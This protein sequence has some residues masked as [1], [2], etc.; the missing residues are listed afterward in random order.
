MGKPSVVMVSANFH[1]YIGG[2]EKQA[3]EL[4]RALRETGVEVTVL[5]RR[6]LRL[7]ASETLDGVLIRRLPAWGVGLV[8]SLVFMTSCF[9]WLLTHPGR[10]AAV[11]VH[12]AGSPALAACL[13]GRLLGKRVIVKLGGGKGIGELAASES[14]F[15]GRLKL[16][17]LAALG[18]QFVAV[19]RELVA[20]LA[21]HGLGGA[22]VVIQ[23]NGVD[24]RAYHPPSAEEKARL[25]IDLRMPPGL[26]FLYVG[27]LA[28]EKRLDLFV[29][30]L[31]RAL[32]EAP[33]EAYA[34]LVGK[35]DL[36][37]MLRE[38]A[39]ASGLKGRVRFMPPTPE[40]MQLYRA[41]DVF[42]LPSI[43]EGLSNALL[44]A[45]ASGLAV[46][47]SRVG[48]SAEAIVD[49]G[50]GFL[51][52]PQ[53]VATFR[54]RIVQLLKNPGLAEKLGLRGRDDVL[55]RFDLGA[56]A[57]RYRELYGFPG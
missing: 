8:D 30:E 54:A 22:R 48:G 44:E 31:G 29:E 11:H 39:M 53:D 6:I 15:A 28:P 36:E 21:D 17:A 32:K 12:L 24:T 52:E 33:A 13:A 10:Y 25:R 38:V 45:M 40:I 46:L 16:K 56:V 57:R 1:P 37:P 23:P 2:A 43:S 14:S 18:P 7:P 49:G 4:S 35:G 9:V 50:S 41:A 3:L 5:T 55:A 42:V 51:F 47:A 19:N 20:E 26:C 27:R 34:V